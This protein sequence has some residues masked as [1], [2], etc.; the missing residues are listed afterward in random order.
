MRG[1]TEACKGSIPGLSSAKA[2]LV[3][4]TGLFSPA[5]CSDMLKRCE[6]HQGLSDLLV[7]VLSLAATSGGVDVSARRTPVCVQREVGQ[8]VPQ[9]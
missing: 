1:S 3:L 7:P 6:L 4:L 9:G 5:E 8:A 2:W